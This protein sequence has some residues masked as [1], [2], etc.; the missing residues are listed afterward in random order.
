MQVCSGVSLIFTA[1]DAATPLSDDGP[2]VA[3]GNRGGPA[4][5]DRDSSVVTSVGTC[6][7][8]DFCADVSRYGVNDT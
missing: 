5:T 6:N 1:G 4:V 7:R 8:R 3:N 2:K